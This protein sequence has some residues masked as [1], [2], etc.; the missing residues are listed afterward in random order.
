MATALDKVALLSF[1][2]LA[3][4]ASAINLGGGGDD[5]LWNYLVD[6]PVPPE[7][8]GVLLRYARDEDDGETG[9]DAGENGVERPTFKEVKEILTT[10]AA[11][12]DDLEGSGAEDRDSQDIGAELEESLGETSSN[13]TVS[14]GIQG[15]D[16]G[17]AHDEDEDVPVLV[18]AVSAAEDDSEGSGAEDRDAQDTGP[19]LEQSLGETSSYD[20][21][22]DG[23]QGLDDSEADDED[24]DVPVLVTAVSAIDKD[25]T[26]STDGSVTATTEAVE[27]TTVAAADEYD[28]TTAEQ[29]DQDAAHVATAT[30]N[31]TGTTT[32][33][34]VSVTEKEKLTPEVESDKNVVEEVS[35]QGGNSIEGKTENST[36]ASFKEATE[37][38]EI[39][40]FIEEM[41]TMRSSSLASRPINSDARP[42][43]ASFSLTSFQIDGGGGVP[44]CS[45]I[46]HR[47]SDDVCKLSVQFNKFSRP[48]VE[49]DDF[50]GCV[51]VA[52]KETFCA[53][54]DDLSEGDRRSVEL[55]EGDGDVVVESSGWAEGTGF[56][57]TV[58]Q[59]SCANGTFEDD[60]L[61]GLRGGLESCDK[62]VNAP[63]FLIQSPNYP[64]AYPN[65]VDC[66]TL[67][68]PANDNI[69]FLEVRF[70][71]FRVEPSDVFEECAND[72]LEVGDGPGDDDVMR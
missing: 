50:R 31:P 30:P 4:A 46:V 11:A 14:D 39:P 12:E 3:T 41:R 53:G 7:R 32:Y 21:V 20:T 70:D 49:T 64:F 16:N 43:A 35:E 62:F 68:Y 2:I 63:E 59:I 9:E 6:D 34:A 42:C 29:P 13:D 10:A 17:D 58:R 44:D 71:E 1:A 25:Q 22:N 57:I 66:S 5:A 56:N 48:A 36:D 23:V 26:T 72:Y 65:D 33:E 61:V 55:D 60:G 8:L 52:G 51:V 37:K 54:D 47:A 69:C 18:T 15:L 28:V 45:Y 67:V 40:V 27:T 38:P 19:E 24:E